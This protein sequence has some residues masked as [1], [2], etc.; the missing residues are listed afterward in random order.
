MDWNASWDAGMKDWMAIGLGGGLGAL[1]RYSILLLIPSTLIPWNVFLINVTGS[2]IIGIITSLSLEFGQLSE[3]VRLFVAVGIL[4]GYTT[5]STFALGSVNLLESS[6]IGPAFLYM[7]LS[8]GCGLLASYL[9]ILLVRLIM[10]THQA[11][12][13]PQ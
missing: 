1:S 6:A 7:I 8:L 11:Q 3:R 9:G 10:K 4:G 12:N 2:L 5:F 13:G